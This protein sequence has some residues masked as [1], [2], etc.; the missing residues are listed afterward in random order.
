MYPIQIIYSWAIT[1]IVDI[2][3][4]KLSLYSSHLKPDIKL[5]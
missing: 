1:S 4:L 5:E 3:Q 2:I